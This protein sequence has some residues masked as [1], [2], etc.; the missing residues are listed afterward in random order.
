MANPDGL[1]KG[2]RLHSREDIHQVFRK[3]R[4]HALG[5]LHAKTLSTGQEQTRFLI[6]VKKSLGSAPRRNRIK[7]LVREA[8]RNHRKDLTTTYDICFFL[9]AK[10]PNPLPYSIIEAEIVDLIKRLS[11]N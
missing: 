3:G 1:P 10:P 5:V 6:S 7:R 9:T 4:Y 2:V 8:I 11:K